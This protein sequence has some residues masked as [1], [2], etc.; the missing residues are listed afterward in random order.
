MSSSPKFVIV[1]MFV[2]SL[3][4]LLASHI[5]VTTNLSETIHAIG[6][7]LQSISACRSAPIVQARD[8]RLLT[9]AAVML[10]SIGITLNLTK[11][12][13]TL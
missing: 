5:G 4:T 9:L 1:T 8:N 11:D 10:Y 13:A 3:S 6:I 2:L 12:V 7:P